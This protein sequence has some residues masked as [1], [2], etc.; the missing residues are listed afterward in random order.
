MS[1]PLPTSFIIQLG[2][3]SLQRLV[4]MFDCTVCLWVIWRCEEFLD[5]QVDAHLVQDGIAE[6]SPLVRQ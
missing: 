6:L 5:V 3:H 4:D 2:N 1:G